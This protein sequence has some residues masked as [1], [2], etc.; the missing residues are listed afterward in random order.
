M[1]HIAIA[2]LF[3]SAGA[4]ATEQGASRAQCI[5]RSTAAQWVIAANGIAA[6]RIVAV[7]LLVRNQAGLVAARAAARGAAAVF[8][9]DGNTGVVPVCVT[10]RRADIAHD[11]AARAIIASGIVMHLKA[12]ALAWAGPTALGGDLAQ[13][14]CNANARAVPLALAADWVRGA[15]AVAAR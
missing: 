8:A 4:S 7:G 15:D 1:F 14:P 6:V 3:K 9:R 11:G 2:R 13:G 12:S 10:A 5:P